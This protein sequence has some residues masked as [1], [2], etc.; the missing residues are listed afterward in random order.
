MDEFEFI[1]NIKKRFS[2]RSIGDDCAVIPKDAETDLVITTD[3]LIEGIDFRLDWATPGLIGHKAL[4]VSLSDIAAMGAEPKW[5]MVSIGITEAL[6]K[7]KFL[8][9][10]YDAWQDLAAIFEVELVGGDTSRSP[11]RLVID[12][13]VAG[14][15]PKG[16]GV[17]RSGAK[18]G[19]GVYVSGP[20]GGAA[21]GL[22]VL[23]QGGRP[24]ESASDDQQTLIMKQLRPLPQIR[25]GSRLRENGL[26]SAMID[27]SDGLSSDLAHLCSASGVGAVINANDLP[28]D[29]ETMNLAGSIE[30][31]FEFALNGG[32]DFELLFTA[33]DEKI[34]RS[35]NLEVFRI[36]EVTANVGVIELNRNGQTELLPPAG[37]KHF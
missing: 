31:M 33:D 29:A 5:A 16:T 10:F 11:D 30:G 23:E 14:E 37:F 28:F 32:E 26:A 13:I 20:L 15:V 21:A 3:L 36:G 18:P 6:W 2:L 25:L 1:K 8:D 9:P 34:S 4:A 19:D 12:S 27:L 17:T 22:K 24:K 35:Q 7:A